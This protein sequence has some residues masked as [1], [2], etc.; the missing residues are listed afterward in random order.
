[1]ITPIDQQVDGKVRII[2]SA[3]SEGSV[4]YFD[5]QVFGKAFSFT[6][7]A[8]AYDWVGGAVYASGCTQDRLIVGRTSPAGECD[9]VYNKSLSR[10][11]FNEAWG[12]V[13]SMA[14]DPYRG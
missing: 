3:T 10:E 13:H 1:M 7:Q 8:L 9:I 5:F 6:P 2:V 12:P 4:C 14:I 11:P